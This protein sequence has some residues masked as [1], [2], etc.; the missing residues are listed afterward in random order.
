M[1]GDDDVIDL[2]SESSSAIDLYSSNSIE[3]ATGSD[4]VDVVDHYAG[5][6]GADRSSNKRCSETPRPTKRPKRRKQAD[7]RR[8]WDADDVRYHARRR[9]IVYLLVN[10]RGRT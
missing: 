4:S 8:N 1:A 6:S 7:K 3:D 9:S 10:S 2:C 5:A